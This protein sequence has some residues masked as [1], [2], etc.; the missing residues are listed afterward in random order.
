MSSNVVDFAKA[1]AARLPDP[2]RDMAE[3]L[4]DLSQAAAT[5]LLKNAF[6][7]WTSHDGSLHYG[8][9]PG[10][11]TELPDDQALSMLGLLRIAEKGFTDAFQF[12]PVP[13]SERP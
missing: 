5:G 7:A 3:A 10:D 12:A 1:R 9:V 13:A 2:S 11:L 4:A 8:W 6:V